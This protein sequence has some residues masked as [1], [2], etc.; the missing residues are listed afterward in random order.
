MREKTMSEMNESMKAPVWSRFRSLLADSR[1]LLFLI[2][3]GI[4][5]ITQAV[6]P[7]FF[8]VNNIISIL[9]QVAVMGM[10]TMGMVLLLLTGLSD[11]SIGMNMTLCAIC[12]SLVITATKN[13][14]LAIAVG[15][16]VG[17]VCGFFN[18]FIVSKT[19]CLPLIITIGTTNVFSG[20]A[21]VLSQGRF[22]NFNGKFNFLRTRIF[23]VFPLSLLFMI[24]MVAIMAFIIRRTRFG[25]RCVTVGSNGSAAFLAGI[26]VDFYKIMAYVIMGFICG[27]SSVVFVS[28]LDSIVADAGSSYS[29]KVL[30][31]AIIGGVT[32]EGGRGTVL[33][34]VIGVL[35]IGVVSNVM[36]ILNI[37]TYWQTAL[38]GVITVAAVIVSNI[39]N[40]KRN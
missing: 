33:G 37:N 31:A 30:S 13:V 24:A 26:H 12:I 23:G 29:L 32:F 21:L 16:A 4:S 36:T 39:H 18:G 1:F 19:K 2:M 34:A 14:W 38:N 15:I 3:L 27:L 28:R 10:L 25:R 22:L 7:R 35:F 9:Q 11:L 8:T 17:G 20:L 5:V 40:M 6:N